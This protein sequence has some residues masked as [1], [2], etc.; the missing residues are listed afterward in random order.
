MV[1][2]IVILLLLVVSR[3]HAQGTRT[4]HGPVLQAIEDEMK[5]G[6]EK[7][8]LPGYEKPMFMIFGINQTVV[9]TLSATSGAIISDSES[10]NA[11]VE[12][13]RVLCGTYD[14]NDES[15]DHRGGALDRQVTLQLPR[16]TS[17]YA[18]IRRA[19]WSNME[20]IYQGAAKGLAMNQEMVRQRGVPLENIPHRSFAK[21][22]PVVIIRQLKEET[23][24]KDN[25]RNIVRRLSDSLSLIP[26]VVESHVNFR[27]SHGY[28]YLAS[29]EGQIAKLPQAKASVTMRV[30]FKDHEGF[31]LSQQL[32]F[33]ASAPSKLPDEK[34]LTAQFALLKKNVMDLQKAKSMNE[35]YEGPVLFLGESVARI[36]SIV[37][38]NYQDRLRYDN[39]VEDQD[40][41]A[42]VRRDFRAN[43][44]IGASITHESVTVQL[45]PSLRSH[46]NVEL[47][48]AFEMDAEG[49]VP[50]PVT[51]IE[52][53][54]LKDLMND[55]T[56]VK[57]SQTAN[58]YGGGAV[59]V[60]RVKIAGGVDEKILRDNLM[61]EAKKQGLEYGIV[62]RVLQ[63]GIPTAF[64][65][66]VKDGHE[67]MI[68]Q[69][70]LPM[71]TV[72][73]L[74][75]LLGASKRTVAFNVQ[76]MDMGMEFMP[77]N[78][79]MMEGFGRAMN[80]QMSLIVPDALLL[81]EVELTPK[82]SLKRKIT[83]FVP[84]PD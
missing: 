52:A 76:P 44:K 56:I 77:G 1:R 15:L 80:N 59:G 29:T 60:V 4:A 21:A 31:P 53:G 54:V 19:I 55:R 82:R 43:E 45:E 13:A 42:F 16:D 6:M 34:I 20:S 72:K 58:G 73:G 12:K 25:W 64:K 49:V 27:Y 18:G 23:T 50:Q 38:N 9:Y 17:D 67:E 24:D 36:F 84:S 2:I 35:S 51:L 40:N 70:T 68:S 62:F 22:P 46:E 14:F 63:G 10:S 75:K 71:T 78:F 81:G 7:L 74:K 33:H 48:G 11:E 32:N 47:L 30:E 66:F 65:V 3:G 41:N 37:M 26:G 8:I 39:L 57:P 79:A 83:E 61:V 69:T 5:R 28:S